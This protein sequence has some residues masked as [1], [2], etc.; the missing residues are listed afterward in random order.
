MAEHLGGDGPG[1]P[2]GRNGNP[3]EHL[4]KVSEH[5]FPALSEAGKKQPR[6]R[7]VGIEH[8]GAED[9]LQLRPER[10]RALRR[11]RLEPRP[12]PIPPKAHRLVIEGQVG[13]LEAEDLG[14]PSPR[15]QERRDQWIDIWGSPGLPDGFC[16]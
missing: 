11:A 8:I 14:P 9:F 2:A 10:D 1:L 6:R 15:Q 4:P 3:L 16:R 5:H 13:H 12:R 7:P